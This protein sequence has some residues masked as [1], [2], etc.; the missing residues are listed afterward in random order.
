MVVKLEDNQS[1]NPIKHERI[2]NVTLPNG[3]QY[4]TGDVIE[5]GKPT[6]VDVA[7]FSNG[8]M[9]VKVGMEPGMDLID[10][11]RLLKDSA[12]GGNKKNTI[13][14]PNLIKSMQAA[15]NLSKGGV[16]QSKLQEIA[17]ATHGHQPSS[18]GVPNVAAFSET[19]TN[20]K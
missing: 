8:D 1:E 14:D 15:R 16:T 19:G 7:L 9:H 20:Y 5:N 18:Q 13:E 3:T 4:I 11:G 6:P 2:L 12:L 10:S 17:D